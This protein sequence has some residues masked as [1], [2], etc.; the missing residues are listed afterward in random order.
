MTPQEIQVKLKEI[1][2]RVADRI[3]IPVNED[4]AYG[5]IKK[6][7]NTAIEQGDELSEE[8]QT[9]LNSGILDRKEYKVDEEKAKLFDEELNKEIKQAIQSGELPDPDT[10]ND[11]F[12]ANLNKL[13]KKTKQ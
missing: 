4:S 6:V 12:I 13:W 7:F 8:L 11:P 3:G 5:T 9:V 1:N 2:Q 10:I